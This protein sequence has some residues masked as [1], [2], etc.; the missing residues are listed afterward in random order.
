[1]NEQTK[2]DVLNLIEQV[3]N[4]ARDEGYQTAKKELESKIAAIKAEHEKALKD[5][6]NAGYADGKKSDVPSQQITIVGV[7][8]KAVAAFMADTAYSAKGFAVSNGKTVVKKYCEEE[9][10]EDDYANNWIEHPNAVNVGGKTYFNLIP[11]TEY[12]IDGVRFRTEGSVRQIHFPDAKQ[13]VSNCRDLGGY[14]CEGGRVKYGKVIRSAYLPDGLTKTSSV[15]KV[16][17]DDIGVTMEIDLRNKFAYTTLGWKGVKVSMYGYA[18]V[19][20]DASGYKAT[21]ENIL[22]EVEKGGCVLIHCNAGADRT[23]TVSALLLGVLGVSEA[24]II[25]DWELTSFCHWCNFKRI[26]DWAERVADPSMKAET[27]K[28]APK[29]ELREFFIAMRN[30]YGTKGES[31]QQQCV[32]FLTKKVGFTSSQIERMKKAMIG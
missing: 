16:L 15:T 12:T 24:D 4:I 8:N 11:N 28:E 21:F 3:E 5:A 10:V 25:K 6:Y 22:S 27:L 17:R 7:T 9:I 2:K 18:A 32:S 31:F 26:S 13:Y 1:M 23:G 19:L 20:T 29:G 30:A 14:K